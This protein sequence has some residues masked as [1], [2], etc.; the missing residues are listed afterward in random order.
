MRRAVIDELRDYIKD[1]ETPSQMIQ[2]EDLLSEV[3]FEL[4]KKYKKGNNATLDDLWEMFIAT[5][6]IVYG[7]EMGTPIKKEAIIKGLDKLNMKVDSDG[8]VRDK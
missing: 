6:L 4:I 1:Y 8:R 7:N 3:E 5:A 2:L